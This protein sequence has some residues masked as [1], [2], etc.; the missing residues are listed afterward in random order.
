MEAPV[1]DLNGLRVFERVAETLSFTRAADSLG[2]TP[3]AVSKA[4]TRLEN[5]LG[6]RLLHRTT[7]S[8]NLTADGTSFHERCRSVLTEIA[9]AEAALTRTRTLAQGRLRVQMP[10]GFGRRVVMPALHD[11]SR[12]Y[13]GIVVDVE[14]SDRITDV[15]HEGLDAAVTIGP[16]ADTR[17]IARRL[18]RLSFHAFASPAYLAE[19]GEPVTP[20]DLD[21]HHCLAYVLPQTGRY[22]DWVFMRDGKSYVRSPAGRLNVNN[23]ESL[24]EAAIAGV[25]IVMVST[26]IAAASVRAGQLQSVLR[27]YVGVG[28]EVFVAYPPNRN[29]SARVR[30]FVD[31]LDELM[32]AYADLH[33]L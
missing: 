16:P 11:F 26:F 10:V 30:A 8:L 25:G 29:L 2:L 31:F 18:C 14:L 7:R 17:L 15:I 21:A 20:D 13:P 33:G 24:L 6:V 19:H 27:D 1:W 32:P 23:A 28:P 4:M 9:D 12:D 22:R 5:E 3:S